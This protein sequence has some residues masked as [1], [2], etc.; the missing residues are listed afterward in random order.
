MYEAS[1]QK[2]HMKSFKNLMLN[3]WLRDVRYSMFDVRCTSINAFSYLKKIE[4]PNEIF[5]I[6]WNWT[7]WGQKSTEKTNTI[8]LKRI[9]VVDDDILCANYYFVYIRKKKKRGKRKQAHIRPDKTRDETIVRRTN[10]R[11]GILTQ[12]QKNTTETSK[13]INKNCIVIIFNVAILVWVEE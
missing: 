7:R 10:V 12:L 1:E 6:G 13:C 4:S 5:S 3:L 8:T 2:S 9:D 11:H